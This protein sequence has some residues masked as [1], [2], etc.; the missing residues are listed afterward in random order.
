MVL[1]CHA[2]L[3]EQL[4]WA[5]GAGMPWSEAVVNGAAEA[6]RFDLMMKLHFE[7]N[8]PWRVGDLARIVI[9]TTNQEEALKVLQML[10]EQVCSCRKLY[11]SLSSLV[12]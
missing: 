6:H 3:Q 8:C 7:H 11:V 2:F 5:R 12:T 4:L 9:G 10:W 1:L